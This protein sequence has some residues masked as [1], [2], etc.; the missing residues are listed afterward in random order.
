MNRLCELT[1]TALLLESLRG[2]LCQQPRGLRIS[3]HSFLQGLRGSFQRF[4]HRGLRRR[5]DLH[6]IDWKV[7]RGWRRSGR[8]LIRR[9]TCY[10]L[11]LCQISSCWFG[12]NYGCYWACHVARSFPPSTTLSAETEQTLVTFGGKH[13]WEFL[14]HSRA[15]PSRTG[16]NR[17]FRPRRSR[18]RPA[19]FPACLWFSWPSGKSA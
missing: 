2:L 3:V 10:G 15:I 11:R 14:I 17:A 6:C 13:Y 4:L 18:R 5:A 9:S 8:F 12:P 7:A 1:L 19:G 16:C